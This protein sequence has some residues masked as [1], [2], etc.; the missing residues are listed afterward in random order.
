MAGTVFAEIIMDYS[1][2]GYCL[3]STLCEQEG[4]CLMGI[5]EGMTF[6]YVLAAGE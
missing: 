3:G 5:P 4:F 1:G 6:G 2:E